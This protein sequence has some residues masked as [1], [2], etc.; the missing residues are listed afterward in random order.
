MG[1][2]TTIMIT[3]IIIQWVYGIYIYIYINIYM[4]Y[5]IMNHPP[6]ITI[7]RYISNNNNGDAGIYRDI[8]LV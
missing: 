2:T 8:S 6:V 3:I 4:G 1:K 7:N 5:D